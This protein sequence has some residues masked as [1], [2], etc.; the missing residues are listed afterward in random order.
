MN[1][2]KQLVF[3]TPVWQRALVPVHVVVID[4]AGKSV[5]EIVSEMVHVPID[6]SVLLDFLIGHK[7]GKINAS[8]DEEQ[9]E[10]IRLQRMLNSRFRR[11]RFDWL[12]DGLVAKM[13]RESIRT[14]SWDPFGGEQ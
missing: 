2:P 10:L 1:K 11:R 12:G 9:I 7:R 6:K 5:E 8:L 14:R 4:T 3:D 13:V